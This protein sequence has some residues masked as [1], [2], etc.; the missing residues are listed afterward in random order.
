MKTFLFLALA[1]PLVVR[2]QPYAPHVIWD[3]TGE[4]DS[5]SYGTQILPLGDQNNDGYADWAVGAWGN[6]AYAGTQRGYV[7]FFHG[8][9]SLSVQPFHVFRAD[10]ERF[11][12]PSAFVVGDM[13][14][15][16]YRDWLYELSRRDSLIQEKWLF[17]GGSTVSDTPNVKWRFDGAIAAIPI[18]NLNGDDFDDLL[19][20]RESTNTAWVCFGG[21]L[22]DT[23]ADWILNQPPP[24]INQSIPYANGDFNGDGYSDLL[25]FHPGNGNVAILLGG[26]VPDTIPDYLWTAPNR[27]PI[28]GVRSLNGDPFDEFLFEG[29]NV[30]DVHFGDS[31]LQSVPSTTIQFSCTYTLHA[32]SA[33]DFNH[34]AYNDLLMWDDQCDGNMFGALTL[35]LGHPWVNPEPVFT[36]EGSW[37]DGLINIYTAVSLGD[38]NGDGIDDIAIGAWDDFAYVGWRGRSV[39]IAGDDSLI[40]SADDPRPEIPQKL[41]VNVYPNPFNSEA[42]IKMRCPPSARVTT[43]SVF[44]VLGQVVRKEVLPPFSGEYIYQFH[45]NDLPSGVYLAHVQSGDLQVTEKLMLLK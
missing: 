13:N 15:D 19:F 30:V 43:L 23:T 5:S 10:S 16:G 3:R 45:A 1:L 35:H 39:I 31:I 4:T 36:I 26:S 2:A 21:H 8:A 38:V 40:A 9:E 24:G 12:D 42:R 20:F 18:G 32:A 33:G 27:A 37:P 11:Y 7:E 34:D 14:G 17:L 44:N 28:G 6:F 29:E 22:V 25:F 41:E